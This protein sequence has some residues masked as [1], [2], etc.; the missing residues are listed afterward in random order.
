V[1]GTLYRWRT[2]TIPASYPAGYKGS[3]HISKVKAT[4]GRVQS[5]LVTRA[6]GGVGV[7]YA[8]AVIVGTGLGVKEAATV[9]VTSG[10][11]VTSD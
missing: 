4:Y 5:P 9:G 8:V 1:A 2:S 6:A 7:R 3:W 11:D 10:V